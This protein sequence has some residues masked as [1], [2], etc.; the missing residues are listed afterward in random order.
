[1][2]HREQLLW[3]LLARL[4]GHAPAVQRGLHALAKD[5]AH[6][7]QAGPQQWQA[8][9]APAE[10]RHTLQRW[11]RNP[12]RHPA[13]QQALRDQDCLQRLGAQ[14][15]VL[16]APGYPPLLGEIYDPP[17]LLYVRG[18]LQALQCLQLA[19]VGSRRASSSGRRSAREFAM[20]FAQSGHSVCSGLAQGIDAAAHEGALD[21]G[22]FTLA[23]MGTGIDRCY[24]GRH[25]ELAQR[26]VENGVL[27]T[28]FAPGVAPHG[29]HFPRRNRL[30]SGLSM[31]VVVAEA[32]L[33]SG[34]L[35]TARA[36]MEQGR[37][38]FA[39]PHSV[40]HEGGRGCHALIRDGATLAETPGEVLQELGALN[41][42][43]RQ[44]LA[45]HTGQK[46]GQSA[47]P[48]GLQA[49]FDGVGYEPVSVDQL[50]MEGIGDTAAILGGLIELQVRGLLECR[51]GLYM[52]K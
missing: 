26:I 51:D 15:L 31:G 44:L 46:A 3:L 29:H 41:A 30:I 16:G 24:P 36:A 13:Q 11:Q 27:L 23:V 42:A 4:A 52:R 2:D 43:H 9:G 50:V 12:A 21:A 20:A 38:V 35:I 39:L 34:S 32:A 22:G 25:G 17:P 10:L 8:A 7:L 48:A 45:S 40:W 6:I 49:I 5:P 1:M 18:D 28:E 14:L 33:R 47:L 19:I 37:E